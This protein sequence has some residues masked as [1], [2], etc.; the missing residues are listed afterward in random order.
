M[1]LMGSVLRVHD[2]VYKRTG[3][4]VGHR[5]LGV[6]TLLLRTTGRRSGA[7]RSNAL[8][9]ARDAGDYLVVPSAGGS[10]RPPAWFFNL[11]ANP[12]VELQIGRERTAG[13]ATIVESSDP[14]YERL[15]NIV[16]ANNRERYNGYQQKT[17]RPIPVVAITPS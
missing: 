4:R 10:D 11:Q 9:Y 15:W 7:T 3:G 16:N 13:K 1:D 17:T 6:P 12:A 8:V 14:R 5:V 2:Q